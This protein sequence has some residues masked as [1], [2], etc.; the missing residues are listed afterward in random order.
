MTEARELPH[1]PYIRAVESALAHHDIKPGMC[2]TEAADGELTA[3]FRDWPDDVVDAETWP[4]GVYL[5]WDPSAGWQLVETGDIRTIHA[6]D[7]AGVDSAFTSPRQVACS[8][9]NAL[10]GHLVTGPIAGDGP[11]WDSRPV[12][13]AITAWESG[14]E[15]TP[16]ITE[17]Q[18]CGEGHCHCYGT[19]TEHADCACGCDCPRDDD[20]QLIDD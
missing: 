16:D 5:T 13:A 18:P 11:S 6:L 17:P 3:V 10:R 8:A 14:E 12:E 9:D 7:P 20:G 1:D 4:H 2:W 19:G 15:P